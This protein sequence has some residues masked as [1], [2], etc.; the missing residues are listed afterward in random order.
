MLLGRTARLVN[1][2]AGGTARR[3]AYAACDITVARMVIR[4]FWL[5]RTDHEDQWSCDADNWQTEH[6]S[7]QNIVI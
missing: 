7:L 5:E 6:V 3:P 4:T 2:H 1:G